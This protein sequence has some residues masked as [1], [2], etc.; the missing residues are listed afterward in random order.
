MSRAFG[1]DHGDVDHLRGDDRPEMDVESVGEEECVA[2]L[3]TR[4]DLALIDLGH[5]LVRDEHHHHVRRGDGLRHREDLQS[6]LLRFGDAG[7]ARAKAYHDVRSGLGQVARMSV[8]LAA[9]SDHR[10]L[11]LFDQ[12]GIAITVV[13][14]VGHGG[15]LV[16]SDRLA[17]T[18]P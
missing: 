14:D 10:D 17:Q 15:I 12:V 9:I 7:G 5:D 2:L 11:A 16:V 3:E 8:P 6:G 13:V 4:E 1:G 18:E